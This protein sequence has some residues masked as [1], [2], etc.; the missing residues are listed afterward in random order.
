MVALANDKANRPLATDKLMTLRRVVIVVV[1]IACI[2]WLV[3]ISLSLRQAGISLQGL[4]INPES[5]TAA[6]RI[7]DEVPAASML[8]T[9]S[10]TAA[11]DEY[12]IDAA[13]AEAREQIVERRAREAAILASGLAICDAEVLANNRNEIREQVLTKTQRD[14]EGS[15]IETDAV[16]EELSDV[17]TAAVEDWPEC[18]KAVAAVNAAIED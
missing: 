16:Y 14:A 17:Y 10:V 12:A 4:G 11:D 6:D 18:R 15:P 3:A 7:S 9:D 8:R 1:G 2:S 5:S 13:N